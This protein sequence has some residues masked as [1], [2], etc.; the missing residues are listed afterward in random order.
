M[1]FFLQAD[2]ICF[3]FINICQVCYSLTVHVYKLLFHCF[4]ITI[5][6]P[7]L[8]HVHR[9]ICLQGINFFLQADNISFQLIIIFQNF[10]P[11]RT[12]VLSALF[13][14]C[15]IIILLL[16]LFHIHRILFLQG[17]HIFLQVLIFSFQ[18]INVFES[19]FS[20]TIHVFNLLFHCYKI[21]IFL[22]KL[23]HVQRIIFLKGNNFF[24]QTHI[25]S[26]QFISIFEVCFS[27]TIQVFK[28]LFHCCKTIIFLLKLFHV[29]RIL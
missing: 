14:C 13:Q 3:Q 11:F 9:I 6:F 18:L 17:K 15:K 1:N 2:N 12:Q 10:F 20:P 8:S 16:Q 27:A 5:F 28:L 29:H 25:F 26:F 23:F 21:I 24:P 7:H 4:K 19:C 22:L